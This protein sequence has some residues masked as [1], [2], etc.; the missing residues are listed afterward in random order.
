M[1]GRIVKFHLRGGSEVTVVDMNN[2][3]LDIVRNSFDNG[4]VIHVKNVHIA[5]LRVSNSPLR[6]SSFMNEYSITS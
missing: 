5:S 1:N 3:D 2:M 6:I 4:E